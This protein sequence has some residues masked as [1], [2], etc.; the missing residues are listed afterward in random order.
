MSNGIDQSKIAER[1]YQIYLERGKKHGSDFNDWVQAE[2]ELSSQDKPKKQT[3]KK[4][5]FA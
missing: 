3:A 5:I 1:A 2:K 4:K